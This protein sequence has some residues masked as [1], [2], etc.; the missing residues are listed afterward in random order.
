MNDGSSGRKGRRQRRGR[1][2]GYIARVTQ[3]KQRSQ[4]RLL[5]LDKLIINLY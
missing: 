5:L 3:I 1:E 4:V 2:K